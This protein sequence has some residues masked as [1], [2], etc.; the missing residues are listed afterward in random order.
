MS[1]LC[2]ALYFFIKI[3]FSDEKVNT[4]SLPQVPE[5]QTNGSSADMQLITS[6]YYV[7]AADLLFFLLIMKVKLNSD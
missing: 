4:D 3:N 2:I 5:E 6:Q 7:F 1:E